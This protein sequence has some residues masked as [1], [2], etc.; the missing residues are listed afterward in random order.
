MLP[1]VLKEPL[2]IVCLFVLCFLF[3]SSAS[4]HE[5]SLRAAAG[6]GTGTDNVDEMML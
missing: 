3:A 2:M 6:K 1:V 5:S 4:V